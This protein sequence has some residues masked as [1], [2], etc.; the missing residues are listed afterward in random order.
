M[1]GD[2]ESGFL[3]AYQ[4][5]IP[6][7]LPMALVF[8]RDDF[9]NF[10][11]ADGHQ[12]QLSAS[13]I[14][15]LAGRRLLAGWYLG[16][17]LGTRV[18]SWREHQQARKWLVD[19]GAMYHWQ[20][21]PS[22]R[23]TFGL[24]VN[25]L[26]PVDL[27]LA[28]G[29]L[30]SERRWQAGFGAHLWKDRFTLMTSLLDWGIARWLEQPALAFGMDTGIA[31]AWR[32]R[33]GFAT[34]GKT[35]TL[36]LDWKLSPESVCGYAVQY[37]MLNQA[38]KQQLA[39]Q[40]TWGTYNARLRATPEHWVVG[41][42]EK[43]VTFSIELDENEPIRKWALNINSIKTGQLVRR[44]QGTSLPNKVVWEGQDNQ[45]AALALGKYRVELTGEDQQGNRLQ[46]AP[47]TVSLV[48][49]VEVE[50]W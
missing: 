47:I 38:W 5:M 1:G 40:E 6:G 42:K 17:R 50:L 31:T 28:E 26:F 9:Q 29:I 20:A 45:G 2:R 13:T 10:E 44:Y 30:H 21:A 22:V 14:S 25:E 11:W 23:M 3:A 4:Q 7:F 18:Y 41:G 24:S 19:M 37:S 34:V 27:D 12:G 43:V 32:G 8:Q 46:A 33:L 49:S 35:A 39:Y 36:G 15:L 48:Q 16:A